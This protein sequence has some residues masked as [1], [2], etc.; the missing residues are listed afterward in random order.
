M[1]VYKFYDTVQKKEETIYCDNWLLNAWINKV[2]PALNKKDEDR[3]YIVDGAEGTGK[4][5]FTQQQA[6][7]LWPGFSHHYMCM[8]PDELLDKI[9]TSEKNSVIVYDEA[10]AG[11]GSSYALTAISKVLKS[12]IMEMR[13]K[14]LCVF[15]VLPSFFD[16]NKYIVLHRA[17]GLFHIR[18]KKGQRGFWSYYSKPKLREMW[19]KGHKTY[20]YCVRS[21]RVGR[22]P[23]KYLINEAAYRKKKR[24]TLEKDDETPSEIRSR[25]YLQK[26]LAIKTLQ[27]QLGLSDEKIS[28]ILKEVH[29]KYD[30]AHIPAI[31]R[32]QIGQIRRKMEERIN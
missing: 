32:A 16:L 10:H 12:K 21:K 28:E 20:S 25:A 1:V 13:Q 24:V 5:V 2:L 31:S 7:I 11:L 18:K 30:Y 6:K 4:S 17:S 26:I 19:I 15:V 29:K 27:E 8:S 9:K 22:F 3:F 23:D 14:N